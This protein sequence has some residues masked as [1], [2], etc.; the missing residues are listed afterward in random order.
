MNSLR[1]PLFPNTL[2]FL[3][4]HITVSFLFHPNAYL[5]YFTS[6][7]RRRLSATSQKCSKSLKAAPAWQ[8]RACL[9]GASPGVPSPVLKKTKQTTIPCSSNNSFANQADDPRTH[10]HPPCQ[11][12]LHLENIW[13]HLRTQRKAK[14]LARGLGTLIHLS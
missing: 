12:C 13:K 8:W 14:L 4:I 2:K 9:A 1:G 11:S 7:R 6:E 5:F 3:L 10:T